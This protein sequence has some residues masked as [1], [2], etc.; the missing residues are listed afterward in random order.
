MN[1]VPTVGAD[2][3]DALVHS[4]PPTTSVV[5][6]DFVELY[7]TPPPVSATPPFCVTVAP[8]VA[9]S[10]F[11]PVSVAVGVVTVGTTALTVTVN[12]PEF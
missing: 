1:G 5:V 8:S 12:V 9:V 10:V 3:S 7:T 6:P 4:L 2:A 11:A